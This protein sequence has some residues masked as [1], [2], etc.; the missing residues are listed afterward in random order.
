MHVR[1]GVAA[2]IVALVL[3]A[4][5]AAAAFRDPVGD[6]KGP[7]ISSVAINRTRASLTIDIH[8]A[9]RR[10]LAAEEAIQV[11]LDLDS[12]AGTGE[13]GIDL[14]ALY[15]QGEPSEVLLWQ[16]NHYV[17]TRRASITW[18][19]STAHVR[20]PLTLVTRAVKVTAAALGV[21]QDV[22]TEEPVAPVQD[23]VDLAPNKGAFRFTVRG[24]VRRLL[25][26]AVAFPPDNAYS[27]SGGL[28]ARA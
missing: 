11:E 6:T 17:E 1:T 25:G 21:G 23:P 3:A 15:V 5:G 22:E 9:N 10:R 13:D 12:R 16:K 28:T 8:L 4:S 14:H 24:K 26:S 20:V 2:L 19:T 18:T 27:K 7:D